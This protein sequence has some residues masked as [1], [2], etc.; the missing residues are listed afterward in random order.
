MSEMPNFREEDFFFLIDSNNFHDFSSALYGFAVDE[1]GFYEEADEKKEFQGNGT[2]VRILRDWRGLSISQDSN[3]SMG[4]YLY[5]Y[6]DY[7]AVSNSFAKLLETVRHDHRITANQD[8]LNTYMTTW[9]TSISFIETA[10][11]EISIVP[12]HEILHIGNNGKLSRTFI[13]RACNTIPI[14]S[15][16]GMELLDN[17]FFRWTRLISSLHEQKQAIFTDLSGGFDSRLI[18]L[19]LL[20]SGI[21]LNDVKII[22]FND[23]L[24]THNED[25][26]IASSI[27]ERY[28]FELNHDPDPER[29]EVYFTKEEVLAVAYHTKYFFHKEL[30]FSSVAVTRPR[31]YF[32]G[33]GGETIRPYWN[34]NKDDLIRKQYAFLDKLPARMIPEMRHSY[35][36]ILNNT[37]AEIRKKYHIKEEDSPEF[38]FNSFRDCYNRYHFGKI[39]TEAFISNSR[40]LS[41]AMDPEIQK[42]LLNDSSCEDKNLLIALIFTRYAPELL[43]FKFEGGRR[44]AEETL[45][46]AKRINE[47]YPFV[48]KKEDHSPF[49]I[50]LRGRHYD[51]TIQTEPVSKKVIRRAIE[52]CFYSDEYY[53]RFTAYFPKELYEFARDFR[54][55][56]RYFPL[57]H[58]FAATAALRIK[59]YEAEN[60]KLFFPDED[61]SLKARFDILSSS[62]DVL[63]ISD[64]EA[65]IHMPDWFQKD[66]LG[67]I[68]ESETGHLDLIIL[69]KKDEHFRFALRGRDHKVDG[70]R[71]PEWIDFTSFTINGKEILRK[72]MTVCHDKPF[73]YEDDYKENSLIRIH[74]SWDVSRS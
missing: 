60:R 53:R 22:S 10:I 38:G 41:P 12:P 14:D 49:T 18:F 13:E 72:R 65:R 39:N 15:R 26:E 4:L 7:F 58:M 28:S 19:L 68:V 2:Y 45:Y 70:E 17:W 69:P 46:E 43:D 57:R 71:V 66:G 29:H 16:K 55:T 37:F 36:H 42:L 31:F 20:K 25:Y 9:I 73:V 51:K 3:G 61:Y 44:F 50:L 59:E 23:G 8:Y 21:S 27:A 47:K 35:D 5:Q 67:Q 1:N 33:F 63:D 52:N 34:M 32:G 24:H 6:D 30:S 48:A 74:L 54:L 62:Y 64:G 56:T 11:R 40:K